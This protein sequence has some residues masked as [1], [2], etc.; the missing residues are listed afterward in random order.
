MM[1]RLALGVRPP[2]DE[3]DSQPR[4]GCPEYVTY[5]C[6]SVIEVEHL[7]RR[8]LAQSLHQQGEHVVLDLSVPCLDGEDETAGIV[9]ESMDAQRPRLVLEGERGTVTDIGVPEEPGL[10]SL[11]AEARVL[12][13][14]VA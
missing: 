4:T 11:P 7:G 3:G 6:R 1:E 12:S 2:L 5:V 13:G 10:G 9:K 8:I 14:A